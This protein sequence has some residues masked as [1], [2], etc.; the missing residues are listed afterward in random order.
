MAV[1]PVCVT[2]RAACILLAL[3]VSTACT[4]PRP[5]GDTPATD[6]AIDSAPIADSADDAT[7]DGSPDTS[8]DPCANVREARIDVIGM[9]Q[10]GRYSP[11][12]I[13]L[14][15]GRMLLAGG[16][17]FTFGV[18]PS[19][20]IVDPAAGTITDTGPLEFARNFPVAVR[21]RDERIAL[22]GGF[23]PTIGSLQSA[24]I[25]DAAAGVFRTSTAR[26]SVG[27]EAHTATLLP[28]GR[29]L[30]AGGLQARGFRFHSSAQLYDPTSD[31]FASVAAAMVSPR[32]FHAAVWLAARANVLLVGGDSGR[33]ELASAERFDPATGV[34]AAVVN[35][36]ARR[37]K[38]V[39]AV[40]LPD[41][42]VLVAGG[43]NVTDGSLAD[44]DFYDPMTD[45]FTPAMPMHVRR[46]AFSLTSLADGR[47]LASGGW[48]DTETPAQSTATLELF[49]PMTGAWQILPFRMVSGRHDHVAI[50]VDACHVVIAGGQRAVRDVPNASGPREVEVVTIPRR[51]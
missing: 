6:A 47:V 45:Q 36:R 38:A 1:Y 46:M 22:F 8:I 50:A 10:S 33:G 13:A 26:M 4:A 42:R 35:E 48:S 17:D 40:V 2:H 24:E 16:Y 27:R 15:P 41:G 29:V 3:S 20:E 25:Y 5:A 32:A 30:V 28:D 19:A 21:L 11:A 12:G 37:G 34:F 43:A 7:P 49:D 9:S 31:S 44:A 18:Q 23:D 14:G 51:P 39:A